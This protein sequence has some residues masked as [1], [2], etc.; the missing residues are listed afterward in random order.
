MY[1]AVRILVLLLTIKF[2]IWLYQNHLEDRDGPRQTEVLDIDKECKMDADTGRCL[3]RHRRTGEKLSLRYEE[4]VA[5]AR[6]P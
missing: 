3:C 5:M 6:K 2:A 1:W 4:C